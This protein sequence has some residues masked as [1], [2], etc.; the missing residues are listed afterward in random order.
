VESFGNEQLRFHDWV[1]HGEM[2]PSW[3]VIFRVCLRFIPRLLEAVLRLTDRP[4]F[5][6]TIVVITPRKSR[7]LGSNGWTRT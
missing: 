6:R 5:Y 2:S 1:N 4:P 3:S 7:G